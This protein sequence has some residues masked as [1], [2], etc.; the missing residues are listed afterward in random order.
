MAALKIINNI[1]FHLN[2][3]K[4]HLKSLP[5]TYVQKTFKQYPEVKFLCIGFTATIARK[6]EIM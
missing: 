3:Y 4:S 5:G 1:T 6:Y 2:F